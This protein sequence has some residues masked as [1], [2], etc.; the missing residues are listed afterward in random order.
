MTLSE[1]TVASRAALHSPRHVVI[2]LQK[3]IAQAISDGLTLSEIWRQLHAEGAFP[4]G[5]DRFRKLV[6]RFITLSA[7]KQTRTRTTPAA[8]TP[9]FTFNP[10]TN[11]NDLF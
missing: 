8:A 3:D 6:R 9:G 2:S 5:Y 7:K 10:N 1:R 4:A 11:P